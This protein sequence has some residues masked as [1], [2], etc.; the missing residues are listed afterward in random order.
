MSDGGD[1]VEDIARRLVTLR[2]AL[3][4]KQTAFAR[5]IGVTQSAMNNYEQALRR[6]QLDVAQRIVARTGV[7]LDWI[8]LG[9]RS[10]LPA[11]LHAVLPVLSEK[12]RA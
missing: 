12:K 6:P 9:N 5:L 8:Y 1:S 2:E 10:G 4:H 11:H 7:T 3:G